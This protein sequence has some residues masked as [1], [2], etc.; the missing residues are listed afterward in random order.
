MAINRGF[1][2]TRASKSRLKRSSPIHVAVAITLVF[3]ISIL[4]FFLCTGDALDAEQ[5][6][7]LIIEETQ[8]QTREVENEDVSFCILLLN[9]LH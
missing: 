8:T 9:C 7:L 3:G 5:E 1:S 6:D 4:V 2:N